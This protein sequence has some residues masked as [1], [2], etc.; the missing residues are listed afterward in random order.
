MPSRMKGLSELFG[1]I[2][3]LVSSPGRAIAGCV[4]SP[5]GKIA[6]CLKTLAERAA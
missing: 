1:E 6:G 4:Q 3:M 5:A 2:A